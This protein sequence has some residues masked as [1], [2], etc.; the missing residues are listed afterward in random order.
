[1]RARE[2]GRFLPTPRCCDAATHP[3]ARR[4]AG[5]QRRRCAFAWFRLA[6]LAALATA[7]VRAGEPSGD[8]ADL[9]LDHVTIA[10]ADLDSA[11]AAWERLGF[12]I[13]PGRRHGNGIR[14]AHIKFADGS[15]LELLTVSD[16][17]DG[18]AR[19]YA[20][21]IDAHPGTAAFCALSAPDSATLGALADR[22][23][24][25]GMAV[26]R[27]DVGYA[28]LLH[29]APDT[30][31]HPLF[32]IYYRHPAVD[33]PTVT[34]HPNG[35]AAL[36][37]VWLRPGTRPGLTEQLRSWSRLAPGDSLVALES[38]VLVL[39]NSGSG[40]A[41]AAVVV[42]VADVDAAWRWLTDRAAIT[43]RRVATPLGEGLQIPAERTGG[44]VVRLVP[45]GGETDSASG[46]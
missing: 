15:G 2:T 16:P 14:N 22:W 34:T 4:S 25:A 40:P 17:G 41:I 29:S 35:A 38:G 33:P 1:M 3:H 32:A 28:R 10:V 6:V 5:A 21:H 8:P 26:R 12:E 45:A 23:R 43:P 39:E 46:R 18:L 19:W 9:R 42:A 20:G 37:G 44:I 7:P 11:A 36:A 30:P 24:A 27:S 13:K 31:A